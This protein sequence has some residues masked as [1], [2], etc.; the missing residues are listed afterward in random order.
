MIAESVSP[1]SPSQLN[2]KTR[3][4]TPTGQYRSGLYISVGLL[5]LDFISAILHYTRKKGKREGGE[6]EE[7]E[8]WMEGKWEEGR[9]G[10][11]T[12]GRKKRN[13]WFSLHG[14]VG[15]GT[16]YK[17]RQTELNQESLLYKERIDSYKVS[18]L[19]VSFKASMCIHICMFTL[20]DACTHTY[21]CTY[22]YT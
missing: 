22:P 11:H 15:Q 19:H 6:K 3:F 1:H 4:V 9:E 13:L 8:G 5:W 18:E 7:I 12:H 20:I 16:C 14:L 17:V 10:I 21:I 2:L